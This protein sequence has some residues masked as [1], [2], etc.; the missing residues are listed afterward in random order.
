M[1]DKTWTAQRATSLGN[2]EWAH[3]RSAEHV[4]A[5]TAG[6][7]GAQGKPAGSERLSI[8]LERTDAHVGV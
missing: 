7:N 6:L 4:M 2:V 5:E 1:P 8:W 3:T